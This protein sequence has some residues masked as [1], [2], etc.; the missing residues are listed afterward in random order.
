MI[1]NNKATKAVIL[2]KFLS[3]N[4]WPIFPEAPGP[5]SISERPPPFPLLSNTS[6]MSAIE[7]T[8]WIATRLAVNVSINFTLST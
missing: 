1:E 2:L 8:M 6:A 4:V 3:A 5:P 7:T